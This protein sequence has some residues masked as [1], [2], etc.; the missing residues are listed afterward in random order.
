MRPSGSVSALKI[1]P[2][3]KRI[4]KSIV[5]QLT[6][7]FL[8]VMVV[9]ILAAMIVPRIVA[10]SGNHLAKSLAD[11]SSLSNAVE[12]FRV[13]TGRVPTTKEGLEA[14]RHPPKGLAH[15]KGPYWEWAIP[16]DEWGRPFIYESSGPQS[17]RISSLGADGEPG[18][19]GKD[20]DISLN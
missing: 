7:I 13:D 5:E 4:P 15:W 17:Y 9:A 14:L 19:D 12:Q 11:I 8:I 6:S 1:R 10:R 16:P 20:A 2:A 3:T 18:G